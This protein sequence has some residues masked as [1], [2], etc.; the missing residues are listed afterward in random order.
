MGRLGLGRYRD[1]LGVGSTYRGGGIH[2]FLVSPG[3]VAWYASTA[4]REP[5]GD[6]VGFNLVFG[7]NILELMSGPVVF[8]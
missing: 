3:P 2:L 6:V 8:V 5:T 1:P 4:R 7:V